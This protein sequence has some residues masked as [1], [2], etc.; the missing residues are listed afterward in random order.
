[1]TSSVLVHADRA[2]TW[3]SAAGSEEPRHEPLLRHRRRQKALGVHHVAAE[4]GV[5]PTTIA[6]WER[7][8]RLPGPHH[9]HALARV[10]DLSVSDVAEFFDSVRGPDVEARGVRGH[11]L[12]PLRRAAGLSARSVAAAAGVPVHSVY[13]W[14]LGTARMPDQ[15]VQGVA[16]LMGLNPDG[17]VALLRTAPPPPPAREG[18]S[19]LRR[20]RHRAGLSQSAVAE[21]I[22]HSRHALGGW[23]RGAEPPLVALRRLAVVYGV[24]TDV[25]ARAARV[26]PPPLLDTRRW[27]SGTIQDV[28]VVMRRWHG[29]TQRE[30]ADLTGC[31][32]A[33]VRTWEAGLHSPSPVAR[34]GLERAYGLEPGALLAT[35]PRR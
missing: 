28:L 31:S 27:K 16:D 1:M 20:L 35:Y 5:H 8:A 32:A 14:E 23:E 15:A 3:E 18:A 26:Q 6:R 19:Q 10:L 22:G 9:V 21:R 34:Q 29:L 24:P 30:V 13:N 25:V 33:A 17:L 2:P 12:R 4:V 7:R 11:G